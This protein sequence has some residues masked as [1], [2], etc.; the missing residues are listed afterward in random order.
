MFSKALL[1]AWVLKSLPLVLKKLS[2]FFLTLSSF[3]LKTVKQPHLF[4]QSH[5]N[6]QQDKRKHIIWNFAL[7][8][9][10]APGCSQW[11]TPFPVEKQTSYLLSK[12]LTLM[13][14]RIWAIAIHGF[15]CGS[16][17]K[18]SACNV[19]D[20]SLIPG[21]GRSPREEK[22]LPTSVLWPGE[23]HGLYSPWGRKDSDTTEW[24]SLHFTPKF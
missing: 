10:R 20:H 9:K 14:G 3:F 1:P 12:A 4:Q 2:S 22:G 19:G 18:E 11:E 23:F 17:G 24:L 8:L 21:L 16:A 13:S 15:P 7:S 5:K 6:N